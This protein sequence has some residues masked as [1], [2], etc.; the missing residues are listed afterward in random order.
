M[1]A[2]GIFGLIGVLLG[3]V[4][5]QLTRF[6]DNKPKLAF[7]ITY[8]KEKLEK[9]E[10]RTKTSLSEY[11]IEMV[12]I[13]KV[14]V[15]LKNLCLYH[16]SSLLVYCYLEDNQRKILPNESKRYQMMEQDKDALQWHC[17]K[18]LFQTCDVI[19]NCFNGESIKGILDINEF[20]GKAIENNGLIGRKNSVKNLGSV[21][22]NG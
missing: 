4:L 8:S 19:A 13:G 11:E 20:Y 6:L 7:I 3:W 1:L 22:T 21:T 16:K 10:F 9:E 2:S 12:N 17:N 15:I 14:P 18:E 5:N